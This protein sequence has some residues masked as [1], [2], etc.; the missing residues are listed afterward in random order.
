[1]LGANRQIQTERHFDEI[2]RFGT[3]KGFE[4]EA[5]ENEGY[6]V[7]GEGLQAPVEKQCQKYRLTALGGLDNATEIYLHHDWIHHEKET[8]SNR[9][10]DDRS[11]IDRDGHTIEGLGQIGSDSAK[12]NSAQDAE[13]NPDGQIA[14]EKIRH[15]SLIGWSDFF[16]HHILQ[17]DL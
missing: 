10:G 12:Q 4:Q 11:T 17:V 7:H 16:A 9:H 3:D 15:L 5:Q 8:D 14:F 6:R 1:M 2:H 13:S